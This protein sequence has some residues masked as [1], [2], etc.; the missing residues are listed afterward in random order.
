MDTFKLIT[1][2][3]ALFANN[4]DLSSQIS[5]II[6]LIDTI[7]KANIIYWFLTKYKRVTVTR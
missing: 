5:Y 1:F 6:V 2:T 3:D 4:T 7:E